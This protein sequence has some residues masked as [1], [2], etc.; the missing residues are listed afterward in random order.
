MSKIKSYDKNL[1]PS[2]EDAIREILDKHM[3]DAGELP[4][5]SAKALENVCFFLAENDIPHSYTLLP[6]PPD[7]K[8]NE[9][10]SLI[11]HESGKVGNEVWYTY[12]KNFSK[13][14]YRL[15]LTVSAENLEDIQ[16]WIYLSDM[17][18]VEVLDW[19][20]EQIL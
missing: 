4:V 5:Y 15:S 6:A 12:G 11:W 20:G 16:D 13:K 18:G 9:L 10:V 8:C 2:I 19:K 1:Y 3:I 7:A 17:K 14:S